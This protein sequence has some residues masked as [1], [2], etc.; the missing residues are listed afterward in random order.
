MPILYHYCSTQ[1]F[2]NII[3]NK[4]IRL[5]SLSLSNDSMEGKLVTEVLTQLAEQDSLEQDDIKKLQ[6]SV[7]TLEQFLD[8][9]GF[10]LSEEGDLL[11]QWRAYTADA[12]GFSIG[13][14]K[15]YLIKL[16][17]NSLCKTGSESGFSLQRVKYN[18]EEQIELLK[19]IYDKIKDIVKKGAYIMPGRRLLDLRT[20][21]EIER[22]NEKIKKAFESLNS[23]ILMLFPTLFLLKN[24]GFKEEKEWRLISYFIKNGTDK[25]CFHAD[26]DKIVPHRDFDLIANERKSIEKIFLGPKNKTPDYVINSFL[27]QSGFEGVTVVPSKTSYR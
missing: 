11:S 9:L 16:T 7:A 19:P 17:T 18:I 26:S 5:S 8:A 14:S 23:N 2:Y 20:D 21:D 22:E 4:T 3:H 13:F 6:Q 24:K 25:C 12:T 27:K 15:E 1:A 10:C